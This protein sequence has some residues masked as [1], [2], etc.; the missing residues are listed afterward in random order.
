MSRPH[1]ALFAILLIGV[2]ACGAPQ[3]ASV[4]PSGSAPSDATTASATPSASPTES[5]IES[6]HPVGEL[7]GV[8]QILVDDL[9]VRAEPTTQSE[10]I[11]GLSAG[12]V[13]V[14]TGALEITDGLTWVETR[15]QPSGTTGW[16][17]AT[18]PDGSPWLALVRDGPIAVTQGFDAEL[19]DPDSGARSPLTSGMRVADLAFAPDGERVA[20]IDPVNG[21]RVASIGEVTAPDP[22]P[23]ASGPVF[24][25]PVATYAAFAPDGS[26]VAF[27]Q[28]QNFLGPELIW[29][30]E[31]NAPTFPRSSTLHPLSWSPDSRLIASSELVDPASGAEGNWEIVVAEAGA[32]AAVRLT[33]RPGIDVSPAWSPDGTTIAFLQDNGHGSV[34]LAL[35]DADGGNSRPL[36]TFDAFIHSAGQPSWSPDGSRIAIA[37]QLEGLGAM[38]HLVDPHTSEHLTINAPAD[39]CDDLTWSPTGTR[40]AF[41]CSAADGSDSSG[42]VASLD[43]A[44][45]VTELGPARRLD[46][47]R[48]LE[49][50]R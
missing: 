23:E 27:L 47:A 24:G 3:L 41:V 29:L 21:P 15:Q 43:G 32:S 42:Y 37:Q 11:A 1:L 14:A 46:W 6:S 35:M 49:P 26:A 28:G 10:A 31:G 34:A 22:T 25:P 16:V 44:S 4:S 40:I 39:R 7:E 18:G 2:S 48:T 30:G 50:V 9:R 36:L 12:Q 17:A 20:L 13:V 45:G 8:V 38:V 5:P 33:D 19:V